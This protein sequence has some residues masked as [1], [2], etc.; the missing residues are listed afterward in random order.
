LFLGERLGRLALFQS[1]HRKLVSGFH[2]LIL[3]VL[4][5]Q[6][7]KKLLI[8]KTSEDEEGSRP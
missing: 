8:A 3:K 1:A 4:K 2:G 6:R 5:S 7:E